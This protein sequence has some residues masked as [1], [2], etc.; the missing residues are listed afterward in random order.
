MQEVE[1]DSTTTPALG[2]LMIGICSAAL[3]SLSVF[4]IQFGRDLSAATR[5]L[6]KQGETP[7]S[8]PRYAC[9]LSI[10]V[11]VA[12]VA[13]PFSAF[14]QDPNTGATTSTRVVSKKR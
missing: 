13:P 2:V 3:L 9:I 5:Q 7:M 12:I 10:M 1:S 6:H 14:A 11:V 4:R 8:G